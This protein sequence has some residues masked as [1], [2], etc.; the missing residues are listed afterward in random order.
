[1]LVILRPFQITNE[2]TECYKWKDQRQE[3]KMTTLTVCRFCYLPGAV[4]MATKNI[5]QKR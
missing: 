4:T 1:M 5:L 3:K 2:Q